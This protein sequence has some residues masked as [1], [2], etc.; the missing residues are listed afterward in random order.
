[1]PQIKEHLVPEARVE[2]VQHGVLHAADVQVHAARVVLAARAGPVALVL[3]IAERLIVGRVDVA[4]LI[5]GRA[6]PL[7]HDVGVAVVGLGTIAQVQLDLDPVAHLRQRR[8]RLGVRVVRVEGHRLV[9]LHL[10][11]LDGQHRLRQRVRVAVGVVDDGERLAP[12]A[13][14]G[15]QP[16]AQLVLHLLAAGTGLLQPGDGLLNRLVLAL[17]VEVQA[18]VVRGVHQLPVAGVGLLIDVAARDDLAN[19]QAQDLGE[20]VVTGVVRRDRHDRARAVAGK[21]VVGGEDRHLLAG[22]RV[23]GI[24]AQKDA[25]LFLVLLALQ[26]GFRGDVL[27][28]G[29]DGLLRI[30]LAVGPPRVDV[31]FVR[32]G[33]EEGI[34]KL[35]LGGEHHVGR[36][37]QGVRA[38]GEHGDVASLGAEINLRA[39]GA[40]DPIALHG[41]D[42]VGPVEQIQILQQAIRVRGN[43]HHPLL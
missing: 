14:A 28:V 2:Q 40:A 30:V 1:M 32:D 23:G 18:V 12:V 37:E 19:G 6:R 31:R 38:G 42:L 3:D 16:V 33:G 5:P 15:E 24:S 17:A 26:V 13:L 35:V 9:V 25:G 10:G 22:D 7:R 43:A 39:T 8:L 34:D 4:H 20:L 36:T 27:A 29:L 21:H 41:L 11:Q